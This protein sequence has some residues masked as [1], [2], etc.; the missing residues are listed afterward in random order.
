[1]QI[2]RERFNFP[3]ITHQVSSPLSGQNLYGFWID[4]KTAQSS[5]A[6]RYCLPDYRVIGVQCVAD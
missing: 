3:Q 5:T 1:M 6:L 4:L 2:P